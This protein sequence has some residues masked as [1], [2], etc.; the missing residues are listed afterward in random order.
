VWTSFEETG[1]KLDLG[2][3][4]QV[5][6]NIERDIRGDQLLPWKLSAVHLRVFQDA[7][8]LSDV[9]ETEE[10]DVQ[11][12]F[13]PVMLNIRDKDIDVRSAKKI[14]DAVGVFLKTHGFELEEVYKGQFQ[15]VIIPVMLNIPDKDVDEESAREIIDA[16][17]SYLNA[18]GFEPESKDA[19]EIRYGSFFLRLKAS[20]KVLFGQE[21]IE[22]KL[23]K[24][25]Q[26]LENYYVRLPDA[27]VG[28]IESEAAT[29]L[30]ESLNTVQNAVVVVGPAILVKQTV[31]GLSEI[32]MIKLVP[33][34]AGGWKKTLGVSLPHMPFTKCSSPFK[35]LNSRR[36]MLLSLALS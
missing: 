14:L 32:F 7:E 17:V 33:K 15:E 12:F 16:I 10:R 35:S 24:V 26:G 30:I 5:I 18:S 13:I 4:I 31:N 25:E 8:H 22:D 21:T 36:K 34:S 9:K 28:L 11:E 3:A 27:Q 23:A 1:H 6:G 20:M 19:W 2:T 29:K